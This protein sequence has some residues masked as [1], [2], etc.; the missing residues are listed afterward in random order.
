MSD[1]LARY[2]AELIKHRERKNVKQSI[3]TKNQPK[4]ITIQGIQAMSNNINDRR[5]KAKCMMCKGRNDGIGAQSLAILSVMVTAR[6]LGLEYA[7]KP[8]AY[9]QHCPCASGKV[10]TDREM[11]AW[12]ERFESQFNFKDFGTNSVL[13][14]NILA[15]T[16]TVNTFN[17]SIKT[18]DHTVILQML[19]G[20]IIRGTYIIA[21]RETHEFNEY[22]RKD[23]DLIEAWKYVISTLN[24]HYGWDRSYLPHFASSSDCVASGG[25]VASG[26]SINE[27]C[28]KVGVHIRRGD[29]YRNQ[30]R[31]LEMGYYMQ[32]MKYVLDSVKDINVILSKNKI[33]PKKIAFHI[34][35]QG[36]DSF[37]SCLNCLEEENL[38][39]IVYHLD[40][41]L[42][43]TIHH[44]SCSDI[45]VMSKST[46]S[47]LC[48]LLNP[49]GTII[50]YPFW[51]SPPYHLENSWIN[52]NLIDDSLKNTI[53]ENLKQKYL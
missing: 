3:N 27:D 38:S 23:P 5:I 47:Y 20:G 44:L 8:F 7:Y 52:S 17:K 4:I 10:P 48:A 32:V 24:E 6:A 19:M 37:F 25:C 14:D 49:K 33:N 51:I 40:S 28:I 42:N 31:S 12:I 15:K 1:R 13:S 29:A 45:L 16:G 39:S 35:S 43:E 53:L 26:T 2:R 22:F 21:T 46:L 36:S 9:I 11:T 18:I 50:Y 41:D 34:Y 30:R